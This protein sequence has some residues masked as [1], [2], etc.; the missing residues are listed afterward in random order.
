MRK[1]VEVTAVFLFLLVMSG[2]TFAQSSKQDKKE[3]QLRTV[4][5]TVADK[6][7][8]PVPNAIVFL[9]NARTNSVSSRFADS[10]G[11]YKFS[12][13]DPNADYEVHAELDELKSAAK[14][15]SS[16]ESRKDIVLN[17]KLDRKKG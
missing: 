17:L 3:A 11:N 7:E 8:T 9:K 2:L 5:G 6:S 14:T 15:V 4:H 1:L 13:L 16:F 10:E 12:G